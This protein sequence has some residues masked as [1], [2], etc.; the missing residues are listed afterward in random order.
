LRQ[1]HIFVVLLV[2]AVLLGGAMSAATAE[3]GQSEAREGLETLSIVTAGGIHEFSVEVMRTDAQRQRGL[4]FRRFLPQDRGML[5]VFD[6]ERPVAMWMKNTYLRLD[7]VFVARTG[8]VVG[9]AENTEPLSETIIPSGAP[10]YGV[11][12]LNAGV[13]AMIGLKIGDRVRYPAFSN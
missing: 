7:M 12:E 6:S 11:V 1:F 9:L 10:T 2:F 8:R 5:F 13:A 4:M 3:T